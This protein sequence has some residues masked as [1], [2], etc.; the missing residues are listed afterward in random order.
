MLLASL[1]VESGDFAQGMARFRE[2]IGATADPALLVFVLVGV[3]RLAAAWG[4]AQAAARLLGAT[5]RQP[6]YRRHST[7]PGAV[8][9]RKDAAALRASL[10]EE[11]FAAAWAEGESMSFDEALAYALALEP[12]AAP[13]GQAGM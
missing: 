11:A 10:G 13:R 8:Q 3:A 4:N 1:D 5:M 6:A 2:L 9:A 12:P 7:V